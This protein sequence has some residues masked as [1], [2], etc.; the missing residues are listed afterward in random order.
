MTRLYFNLET[1]RFDK[2]APRKVQ[3][4]P[5]LARER[6]RNVAALNAARKLAEQHGIEV[7]KDSAG[8]WWVTCS[9]FTEADD[10]LDGSHFCNSGAEVLEA[11][12]T[13]VAAL[14]A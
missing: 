14:A 3:P 2:G 5:D 11:V 8:G 12:Q 1:G 13:Y 7:D 9:K 10:P 4:N 6:G